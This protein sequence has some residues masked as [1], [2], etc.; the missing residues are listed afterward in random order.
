[1]QLDPA[2]VRAFLDD[3]DELSRARVRTQ[4]HDARDSFRPATVKDATSC[5]AQ[6]GEFVNH[7]QAECVSGTRF[8]RPE[9]AIGRGRQLVEQTYRRRG[10]TLNNAISDA[11]R[12][13]LGRQLDEMTEMMASESV[14]NYVDDIVARYMPP[15][16]WDTRVAMMAALSES[17]G[18]LL[19]DQLRALPAEQ[20]ASDYREIIR[21]VINMRD[22]IAAVYRRV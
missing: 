11:I 8:Q 12:G 10:Q 1:M 13:E 17:F 21:G 19:P 20:L 9:D 7:M 3:L 15:D 5:L 14:E 6:Y 22:Q 2:F 18:S 4:Y 16:S